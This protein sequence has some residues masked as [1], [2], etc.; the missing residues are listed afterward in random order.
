[1]DVKVGLG[2]AMEALLKSSIAK[3]HTDL[4]FY[5]TH[6]VGVFGLLKARELAKFVAMGGRLKSRQEMERRFPNLY[7]SV[8]EALQLLVGFDWP[9]SI[10][11][12]SYG[13]HSKDHPDPT[14]ITLKTVVEGMERE[15]R[16][17]VF[18]E[19][20]AFLKEG[21]EEGETLF[22]DQRGGKREKREGEEDEETW[23][24]KHFDRT[25][26]N[27]LPKKTQ[28]YPLYFQDFISLHQWPR[29]EEEDALFKKGLALLSCL[30]GHSHKSEK[31]D[32]ETSE[33]NKEGFV[34]RFTNGKEDRPL[35]AN[36]YR[37]YVLDTQVRGRKQIEINGK[38]TVDTKEK[39]EMLG[40]YLAWVGDQSECEVEEVILLSLDL[41]DVSLPL[42]LAGLRGF[43][44]MW[45]LSLNRN[46]FGPSSLS[47]LK[48]LS[49]LKKGE[50]LRRYEGAPYK[51]G[52][53]LHTREQ[54]RA[55]THPG[56]KA[57]CVKEESAEGGK[58]LFGDIGG[59]ALGLFRTLKGFEVP[60]LKNPN[61]DTDWFPDLAS[62]SLLPG[63][64]DLGKKPKGDEG[65]ALE[66]AGLSS[67]VGL[68][69]A[70]I[71]VDLTLDGDLK[72]APLDLKLDL[73]GPGDLLDQLDN[74]QL[75]RPGKLLGPSKS[76]VDDKR[77]GESGENTKGSQSDEE[78]SKSQ[79]ARAV[80]QA[81]TGDRITPII[82]VNF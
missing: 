70:K 64:A 27:T 59:G 71:G 33:S 19:P 26:D 4:T 78:A 28:N 66:S 61:D 50:I 79:S 48:H 24:E 63:F 32:E 47:A 52:T 1:M 77:A 49:Q 44:N 21:R 38:Y 2:C 54:K 62:L 15:G 12:L 60:G 73:E 82:D 75:K 76:E 30:Y 23:M 68:G 45:R 5:W 37:Q 29:T 6:I 34:V 42:V 58:G 10:Y 14:G 3:Y 80:L 25:I 36:L 31:R 39:G 53:R 9:P 8:D 13:W 51:K 43:S 17:D 41:N 69:K 11:A 74:L 16:S 7:L 55:N 67:S 40:E 65:S 22:L 46:T 57:D 56:T 20:R 35:V 81:H 18:K 72:T